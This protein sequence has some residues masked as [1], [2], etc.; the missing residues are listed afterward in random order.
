MRKEITYTLY[1]EKN[2]IDVPWESLSKEEQVEISKKLN[3]KAL[4]SIGYVPVKENTKE[5]A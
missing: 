5:T 4:R 1:V 2:G 3:D